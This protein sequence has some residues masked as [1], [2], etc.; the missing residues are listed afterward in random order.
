MIEEL[1][2]V[3]LSREMVFAVLFVWILNRQMNSSE[4]RE[5]EMRKSNEK[6][7]EGLQDLA[8][9]HAKIANLLHNINTSIRSLGLIKRQI[10]I[11]RWYFWNCQ[12]N[13]GYKSAYI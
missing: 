3:L 10:Q 12:Q 4:K 5:K 7:L 2:A 6:L 11:L 13:F 8:Q 9:S 1:I